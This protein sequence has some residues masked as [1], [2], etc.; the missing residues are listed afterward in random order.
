MRIGDRLVKTEPLTESKFDNIQLV[1]RTIVSLVS[2]S[3]YTTPWR[4][5]ASHGIAT[6]IMRFRF[7]VWVGGWITTAVHWFIYCAV[8]L[9]GLQS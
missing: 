7:V 1:W 4:T 8:K 5:S 3:A 2:S 6:D 9:Y